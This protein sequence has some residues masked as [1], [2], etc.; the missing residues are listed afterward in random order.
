MKHIIITETI[1]TALGALQLVHDAFHIHSLSFK[2]ETDPTVIPYTPLAKS[3]AQQMQQYFAG[4]LQTFN[5]PL[6][7]TSGTAFQQRV[8][9]ALQTIPYGVT[10]SYKD[11]AEIV[12]SPKGYRA[13][14]MAN[15]NNPIPI[16]VPCHRVVANDGGLGGYAC[17]LTIKEALL[18]LE[19]NTLRKQ[20][21]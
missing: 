8:W 11:I 4:T 18:A 14:G 9:R 10:K 1:N 15:H 17:G 19:R 13:V 6:N 2:K 21:S 12:G 16:I 20:A 3:C 5:L 7:L